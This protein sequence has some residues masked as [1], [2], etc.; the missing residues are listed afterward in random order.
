MIRL[1]R[2]LIVV[3]LRRQELTGL[4][5]VLPHE[6][7]QQLRQQHLQQGPVLPHVHVERI[8]QRGFCRAAE[9]RRC[10]QRCM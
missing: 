8:E 1:S 2:Q 7:G 10:L 3:V 6:A 9:G 4:H 5:A